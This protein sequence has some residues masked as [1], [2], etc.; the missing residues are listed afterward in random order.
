M[1]SRLR[2]T[3]AL[4]ALVVLVLCATFLLVNRASADADPC[5]QAYATLTYDYNTGASVPEGAAPTD[6]AQSDSTFG[7]LSGQPGCMSFT[8]R[9]DAR[10]STL[11]DTADTVQYLKVLVTGF[12]VNQVTADQ[13][14]ASVDGVGYPMVVVPDSN[15]TTATL[16]LGT[17]PNSDLTEPWTESFSGYTVDTPVTIPVTVDCGTLGVFHPNLV[18]NATPEPSGTDLTISTDPTSTRTATTLSKHRVRRATAGTLVSG[19]LTA[20]KSGYSVGNQT[21]TIQHKV[22]GSWSK[23]GSDVT[24]SGGRYSTVVSDTT[25]PLRAKFPAN[26]RLLHSY[27]PAS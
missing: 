20:T 4:S 5:Q 3:M 19:R 15:G 27:S 13:C 9:L 2:M 14:S 10:K 23:I 26:L 7:S 6:S 11:T 17:D 8:N 1:S 12:D 18:V 21:V 25:H 22:N 16:A 24:G